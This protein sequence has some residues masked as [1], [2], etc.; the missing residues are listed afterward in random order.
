[1]VLVFLNTALDLFINANLICYEKG[2]FYIKLGFYNI[3]NF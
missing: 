3:Y 1:M 2:H